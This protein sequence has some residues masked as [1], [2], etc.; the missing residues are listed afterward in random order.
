MSAEKLDLSYKPANPVAGDNRYG[1]MVFPSLDDSFYGRE[2]RLLLTQR[3]EPSVLYVAPQEGQSEFIWD[4]QPREGVDQYICSVYTRGWNE[5]RKFAEQVGREKVVAGGYHPTAIPEDAFKVAHQVVAGYCGN[6][7]EILAQPDG[8]YTGLFAFTPMRRDLID[9]RDLKQVYP[10]VQSEHIVGSMVSSVGCPFDC[11]FCSTPKMSNRR[12]RVSPMEY[13]E[14]EIADLQSRGVNS[15]F[16]R[17]ESFA[18]N[19]QIV[20]VARMFKGKFDLVYSFGTGN[21]MGLNEDLVRQLGDFGWHSLNFGLEDVGKN[22][23]K[24]KL[25]Q[26]AADNCRENG[27]GVVLSFIVNPDGKT[28]DEAR[29]NYQALYQAFNELKPWQVCANFLMPMPGTA[30]WEQYKSRITEADFDKFDSKTPILCP[31]DLVE[32][33][34]RMIVA[35]Q[36]KYYYSKLYN[37]QVRRFENGD[38]LHL[39]I[40]ELKKEFGFENHDW[41]EFLKFP[42]N[43]SNE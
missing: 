17:D 24:N 39:R 10:D 33:H 26:R 30:I 34:R 5:F 42:T 37:T 31:P 6:I 1:L 43:T 13:A 12:M 14:Q 28:Q 32:W 40:E 11:D 9:Q 3:L 7:D 38:T 22:Y 35:V 23:R 16:V 2:K 36:L 27:I 25:L 41:D 8:I 15:V 20:E 18:T 29:A 19:P 4:N 21:V